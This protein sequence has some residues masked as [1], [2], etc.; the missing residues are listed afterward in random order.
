MI[1]A[2]NKQLKYRFLYHLHIADHSA[3]IKY[4]DQAMQDYNN[5]PHDI[6]NGLTPLE[7]LYGKIFDQMMPDNKF[8]SLKAPG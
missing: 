8:S 5:R 1:E 3:L 2:A 4:I 7:V 6:L